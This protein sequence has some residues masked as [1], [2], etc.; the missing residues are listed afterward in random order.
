[1]T[2]LDISKNVEDRA[3]SD[4]GPP[5]YHPEVVARIASR[6]DIINL[7]LIGTHFQ[8]TDDRPLSIANR[9][10]DPDGIA[11]SVDSWTLAR[12]QQRLGC[13]LTFGVVF[14]EYNNE[15][16]ELAPYECIAKFRV[17]YQVRGDDEFTED[18]LTQFVHWHA[19]SDVWPY[20]REYLSNTL[21]RSGLPRFLVPLMT[22]PRSET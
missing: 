20:W 14:E 17:T 16:D 10:I 6:C 15:F 11:I 7:E 1:M 13:V 4:A 22:A 8:R 18:E 2:R 12:A 21:D 9:A 3:E 5:P 19:V